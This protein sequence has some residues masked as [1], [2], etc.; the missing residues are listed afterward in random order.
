MQTYSPLVLLF[1]LGNVLFDLDIQ[2]TEHA[3]ARLLVHRTEEFREWAIGNHF[4]ERFETGRLDDNTFIEGI[5]GFCPP[6]TTPESVTEAWNAML[7]GIPS[8]RI[9]WLQLQNRERRIAL[10]SNTNILHIRWVDDYLNHTHGIRDFRTSCFEHVFYSHEIGLRKPDGE[11]YRY[12]CSQLDTIP[13]KILFID[14][15]ETNVNGAISIGCQAR[16][17]DPRLDIRTFVDDITGNG[18]KGQK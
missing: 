13:E 17:F 12:V 11:C 14:D 10:L 16:I 7:V 2:A 8:S 9:E 6:G 4:F 15:L 5:L 1:D 18:V 3:L